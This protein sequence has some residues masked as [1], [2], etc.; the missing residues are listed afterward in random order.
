M[1]GQESQAPGVERPEPP[2]DLALAGR[3]TGRST[4]YQGMN[5]LETAKFVQK[6]K[7]GCELQ[8]IPVGEC[9]GPLGPLTDEEKAEMRAAMAPILAAR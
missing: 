9:R 5:V 3:V 6:V 1:A 8:G 7:Y 4:L 2:L